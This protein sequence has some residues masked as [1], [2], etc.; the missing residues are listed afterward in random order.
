[1]AAIYPVFSTP[2]PS[3][4]GFDGS[5]LSYNLVQLDQA[6]ASAGLVSLSSFID[7]RTMELEVLEEDQLPENCPPVQWYPAQKG[8]STVQGLL[9][10][11][12]HPALVAELEHLE[13]LLKQSEAEGVKFHLMVDI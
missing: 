3:A 2:L 8:L 1:M 11:S 7:A 6:A 4:D 9:L 10:L 13:A 5:I 12:Q